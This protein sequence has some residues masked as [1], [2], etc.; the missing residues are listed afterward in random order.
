M[1]IRVLNTQFHQQICKQCVCILESPDGVYFVDLAPITDPR[2]VASQ[3]ASTLGVKETPDNAI[4]ESLI[5]FLQG[6]QVLLLLDNFEQVADAAPLITRLIQSSSGARVLVTSRVALGLRGTQEFVVP[7]MSLPPTIVN[8]HPVRL[9]L[10]AW[11]D[12]K[13]YVCLQHEPP[14]SNPTSKSQ[15][16]TSRPLSRYATA[17]T[18]CLWQSNWLQLASRC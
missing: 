18:A 17:W 16:K 14:R 2:L 6:K 11:Q 9:P 5:L 1:P 7:P 8:G 4:V 12:T 13:P 15:V 3:I 10:I